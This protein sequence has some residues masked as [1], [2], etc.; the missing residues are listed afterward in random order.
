[1]HRSGTGQLNYEDD[2]EGCLGVLAKGLVGCLT[3]T[4][5]LEGKKSLK[6][7]A[8]PTRSDTTNWSPK[9]ASNKTA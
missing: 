5:I 7:S 4:R 3:T 1:M 8:S 9:Q 2:E 6:T